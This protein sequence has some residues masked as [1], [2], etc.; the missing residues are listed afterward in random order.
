MKYGTVALIGKCSVGKSTFINQLLKIKLSITSAKVQTTRNL[1]TG[2]YNDSDAQIVV[3]DTPGIFKSFNMMNKEM[4]KATRRCLGNADLVLFLI[5]SYDRLNKID[6][7]IMD[8]FKRQNLKVMLVVNKSD[9]IT[10][11]EDFRK[12]VKEYKDYYQFVDAVCISSLYGTFIENIIS[13]IKTYMAEGNPL[14][15]DELFTTEPTR[16]LVQ[17]Y[18]R[19]KVIEHTEE[20]IPHSITCLV[21]TWEESDSLVKIGASII[22]EKDGQKAIIIGKGGKM[23][24]TIGTEARHDIEE[25]LGVKVFLDLFV[26]VKED[27]R[28]KENYLK[29]YGLYNGDD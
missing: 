8:N 15:D 5:N 10:D 22:C 29:L 20:E 4:A 27:W 9:L 17:E 7:D 26:K 28:N 21:E 2:I 3:Y 13:D 6:R 12:R 19:E 18:V 1:I 16:F 23:I 25:L 11:E 14:F 24:K